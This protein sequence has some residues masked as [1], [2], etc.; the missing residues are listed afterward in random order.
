VTPA[1]RSTLRSVGTNAILAFA[2]FAA[3]RLGLHFALV[4]PVASPVWP[5]SGVALAAVVLL[6][7]RVWPGVFLGAFLVNVSTTGRF[8]MSIA[9]AAGNTL[10]AL[11]GAYLLDLFND[12]RRNFD[13][14]GDV[15]RFFLLASLASTTVAA[16][17]G[18]ISVYLGGNL[19]PDTLGTVWLT[20]WLGDAVGVLL[21]T[22]PIL[23]W[24]DN[25]RVQWSRQQLIEAAI[26]LATIVLVGRA[27]F[28]GWIPSRLEQ[29]P[30]DFLCIPM[31]VWVAFRFGQR[32]AATTVLVLAW[33]ALSGTVAGVG[34]FVGTSPSDSLLL[35]QVFLGLTAVL[36]MVLA[37]VV[38]ESRRGHEAT[39]RIATIVRSANDAIVGKTLDGTITSWN[40][41]AEKLFGYTAAEA[42][43]KNI[44]FIIPKEHRH[45]EVMVLAKIRAGQVVDQFDTVR[46]R[47]DGT[48]VDISLTVSPVRASDGT[49][50]GASKIARDI[51]DRKRLDQVRNDLLA[52]E[53]EAHAD[54]VAV[55]RAKD[56]FLAVLSHELRTPLNAVYGWARMMQTRELDDE[57]SARALDAIVRNANAQVQLIDDLLD[58]SRVINGKM[59]L[60]VQPVDLAEAI[61]AAIDAVRPAAEAKGQRLETSLD[62]RGAVV[63]GDAGRLQQIVWNLMTNAVKFTPDGGYVHVSLQRNGER[64]EIVVNDTGQGIA[65]QVLPY[66]FDRFRQWDS[67]STRAHSGLGLGLALVKH[68]V[69]LHHG[70]VS[71]ESPGEGQG[72]TFRVMLPL[73]IGAGMLSAH[74][75]K[76]TEPALSTGVRLDGL[77]ILAVDD[78]AD[79]LELAATILAGAGADVKTCSSAAE[80]LAILQSWRPDV[81]VSD[82]DMPGEDGYSLIRNVRALAGARGGR[83][84]AV[85]LTALSRPEERARALSAGFSMH[86]PKPVDPEEFTTIIA[87]VARILRTSEA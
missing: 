55:N 75:P 40:P 52:R 84:P 56:E 82:I 23:L 13:R 54:A 14:P 37:A 49:I 4:N 81:L 69:E 35:L 24:A 26:L 53:Q 21:L 31:F 25:P 73:T 45:E 58:M 36:T 38:S 85:A 27:L 72:A 46:I 64:V 66:V 11:L 28:G 71:A 12:A 65:A 29:Y 6:G 5:A 1:R 61:G 86:V 41:A 83:T 50:I 33:I 59:R 10:E 78:A 18:A 17:V 3:G 77:K 16:T 15:G 32:E 79:A 19:T 20:W 67:S 74:P 9:I 80:G 76:L 30:L 47:K 68:L 42:V 70:T 8:P 7:R 51:G 60:E 57:T 62:P 44:T 87:S 2:Y 63:N 43:G 22:P 48:T 39:E 34:P